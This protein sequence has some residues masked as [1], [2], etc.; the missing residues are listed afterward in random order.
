MLVFEGIAHTI[1]L[2]DTQKLVITMVER[3]TLMKLMS[4]ST[5]AI[6]QGP[7]GL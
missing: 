7:R 2:I 1:S 5:T 3:E 4:L 6:H